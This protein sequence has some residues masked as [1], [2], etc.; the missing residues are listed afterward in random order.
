MSTA[1]GVISIIALS[2][3]VI[4]VSSFDFNPSTPSLSPLQ[5]ID[6]RLLTEY[7]LD[8]TLPALKSAVL[9]TDGQ[10]AIAIF[11]SE[12][13][14][15]FLGGIAAKG[16]S[17]IDGNKNNRESGLLSAQLSGTYFGVSATIRSLAQLAGLSTILVNT[18]AL[19]FSILLTEAIKLRGQSIEPL[20]TRV[21]KG[22][23]MYELM[24]FDKPPMLEL[25]RFDRDDSIIITPTSLDS[26]E[27]SLSRRPSYD[28]TQT[29][30]QADLTK[31]FLVYVLL[32]RN[33]VAPSLEDCAVIGAC[34]GL[35]SQVVRESKDRERADAARRRAVEQ[36]RALRKLKLRINNEFIDRGNPYLN[37]LSLLYKY[38]SPIMLPGLPL[39]NRINSKETTKSRKSSSSSDSKER[40]DDTQPVVKLLRRPTSRA[41]ADVLVTRCARA[42]IETSVQVLT[43]VAARRY[44]RLDGGA[45]LFIL[46]ALN[47]HS[48]PAIEQ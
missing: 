7:L 37:Y 32:P 4:I 9:P 40:M 39:R 10:D 27:N 18:L 20:R 46:S 34:A 43:Y 23:T 35:L 29:E 14:C 22:P 38:V 42:S 12:S 8:A 33:L 16:I 44:V 11:I 24:R 17:L 47:D 1:A 5:Y 26:M 48:S 25:M 3:F 36:K 45:V 28:I 6:C 13:A 30:I 2:L 19:V 31:W 15:G 21:G 41:S